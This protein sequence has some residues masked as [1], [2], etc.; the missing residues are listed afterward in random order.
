MSW[1]S[2]TE[3]TAAVPIARNKGAPTNIISRAAK[4]S[5]HPVGRPRA[6]AIPRIKP[7]NSPTRMRSRAPRPLSSMRRIG[8]GS[9]SSGG[10]K[11]ASTARPKKRSAITKKDRGRM[12]WVTQSGKGAP[13]VLSAIRAAM[14]TG[15]RAALPVS[16]IRACS[17]AKDACLPAICSA[18]VWSGAHT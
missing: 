2:T 6:A 1:I 18:R 7:G 12:L 5:S 16:L 14:S 9:A 3:P 4:K 10:L 15:W 13:P 17:S 11:S 8:T